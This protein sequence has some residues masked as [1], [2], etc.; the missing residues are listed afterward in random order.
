MINT[1]GVFQTY[2]AADLLSHKSPSAI[3]WIGS[4][5]SF[6]LLVVGVVSGPLYDAGHLRLLLGTGASL[7]ALGLMLTSIATEYW[8]VSSWCFPLFFTPHPQSLP[9]F[10]QET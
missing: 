6:F 1:F 4:T 5:Q 2:Y 7:T 10:I 8:K 9:L 3:S